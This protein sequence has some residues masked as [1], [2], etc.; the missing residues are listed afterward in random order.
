MDSNIE[1]SVRVITY[2]HEKYIRQTLDSIF[3]QKTNFN[4]QVIVGEDASPDNTREILL[5][6][7]EKYGD[8]LILVLHDENVGVSKNSL[9]INKY[10]K[11][12]YVANLEG[13]D[14][15]V[16]EYKLQKQY[17]FLE[18]HPE[19]SA[20][21]ANFMTIESDGTIFNNDAL[22]IKKNR[23]Y[24]MKDWLKDGYSVHTCTIF[25]R[26]I[27]PYNDP[28]FI[29]LRQA[30]PTMGDTITFSLLYQ[31]GLIY[32]FKDV[33]SA[34]RRAG[35]NDTSSFSHHEK[36]N[37]IKHSYMRLNI[38]NAL[39]KYFDYKYDFSPL[40]SNRIAYVKILKLTGATKYPSSEM[41]KL[42]KLLPLRV[43]LDAYYRTIRIFCKKTIKKVQ[44]ML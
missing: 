11:G 3:G 13:D 19:Y 25:Y 20:V 42:M 16:D 4:F 32:V 1:V 43:Q 7:K 36:F 18:S 31:A 15:W 38:K 41:R 35:R 9:S 12:K 33:M 28:R 29:E 27:F 40:I 6:Y 30:A 10:V 8:R 17:D 14:Y 2:K 23:T 26:N 21:G 5:E 34:H 37:A 24:S 44:R 22:Q 39:E